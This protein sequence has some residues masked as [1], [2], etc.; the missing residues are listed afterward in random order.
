M[1]E[2]RHANIVEVHDAGPTPEGGLYIAMEY[3]AR[4][5]VITEFSGG[6]VPI[7]TAVR[8]TVDACRGLE[9]IHQLGFIHRDI[10]PAN[11]LIADDGSGK[12][13]DFGLATRV[14][15]TGGASPYGYLSHLAPEVINGY[16]TTPQSDVYAIG[17][18]LYRMLNGDAYLDESMSGDSDIEQLIVAGRFPD[19]NRYRPFVPRRLRT[20]VNKAMSVDPAKRHTSGATLRHALEQTPLLVDWDVA[21]LA[22]GGRLW[23]GVADG[24]GFEST[25]EPIGPGNWAFTL[26]RRSVSGQFRKSTADSVSGLSSA[27]VSRHESRVLQRLTTTGR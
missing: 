19:R 18:T 21:T 23:D 20:I 5:S 13:S 24:Y 27:E 1:S 25:V 12:V 22:G 7:R 15:E 17:V 3:L 4:G 9:Y 6:I 26:K 11:L 14:S 2:L 8:L 16:A 10:K